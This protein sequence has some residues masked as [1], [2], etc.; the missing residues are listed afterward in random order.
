MELTE[1]LKKLKKIEPNADYARK[2]RHII[3]S[4]EKNERV[5]FSFK[6]FAA[7]LFQSGSA[8]VM[9]AMV[10]F[11]VFGSFSLWKLFAPASPVAIDLSGL[12]AEAQAIDIQI[13]LANVAYR[14]PELLQNKTSTVP[15][16][17]PSAPEKN[18]PPVLDPKV[19][20]EAKNLGLTPTGSSTGALINEALDA[21]S[22]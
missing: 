7:N 20:Q 1:L 16:A 18:T 8:I 12:Q 6:H 14:E 5:V 2:S 3:M 11:L 21:L 15:F 13:Q 10:L 4:R 17:H 22:K 19:E 9:T